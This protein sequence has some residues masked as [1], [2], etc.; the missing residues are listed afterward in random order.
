MT[1]DQLLNEIAISGYSTSYGKDK[2]YST[3]DLANKSIT[4]VGLGLLVLSIF[5]L[6]YQSLNGFVALAI[7]GVVG[8]VLLM[9]MEKYNDAKY[10][11]NASELQS[12]ERDLKQLYFVVKNV[13]EDID[14][15]DYE[16]QWKSLDDYQKQTTIEKQIFGSDWYAHVKMFWT[17]KIYTKWYVN[18]LSLKLFF[19]KLPFSFFC[20]CIFIC[21]LILLLIIAF[22]ITNYLIDQGLAITYLQLFKGICK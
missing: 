16:Q 11:T 5:M 20:V 22:F 3:F 1:K 4:R 21:I 17:R 10:L 9:Y 6:G 8:G 7:A 15:S 18:E 14:L 2:S 12:I 19:D 13:S